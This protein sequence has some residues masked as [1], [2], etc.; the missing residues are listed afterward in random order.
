MTNNF[1]ILYD[2]D[3]GTS[4]TI[5]G[6]EEYLKYFRGVLLPSGLGTRYIHSENSKSVQ[7]YHYRIVKEGKP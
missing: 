2:T 5:K 3:K 1:F 7:K 4:I 6:Y